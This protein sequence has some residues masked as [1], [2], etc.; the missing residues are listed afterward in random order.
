MSLLFKTLDNQRMKYIKYLSC[1]L[2][3]SFVVSVA[4]V[5]STRLTGDMG[6]AANDSDGDLLFHLFVFITIV[7]VIRA[8]ASAGSALILKRFSANAGYRFRDNFAKFFLQKP[9][10]SFEGSGSGEVLSVFTNDLPASVNLVSNGGVRMIADAITLAVA[11]VYMLVLNWWLTLIFFVS[12]PVLVSMQMF[13]AVPIQKKSE[14][15]LKAKANINEVLSDSFQNANMVV[16]YSIEDKMEARC[17]IAFS[18]WLKANKDMAQSYMFLVMVGMIASISPVLIIVALSAYQVI[19]GNF[20]IAEWIAYITLAGQTGNWLSMLSQRLN[21]VQSNA[22]GAKRVYEHMDTGVEDVDRGE[23]LRPKGDVAIS[24][25][26]VKFSYSQSDEQQ[27][28]LSD[29][30]QLDPSDE[31]QLAL[32]GVSFEIKKGSRTVFVGSSGSGKS[33]IMKLLLGLYTPQ[34]GSI[35]VMGS[36]SKEVSLSSLR[37]VFSYVPQ[38]NFLFPEP[39]FSNITGESTISDMAKLEKTCRDAGIHEFIQ[40]LPEGYNTVLSESAENI[41]GGQKQRIALARAFYRDA[42]IILFDEATSALDP[43]TEAAFL[44][45]FSN[46]LTGDKTVIMIAHRLKAINFCDT[47][48]LIDAGNIVAVGTHMELMETS[49]MYAELYK[50]GDEDEG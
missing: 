1:F 29:E 11:F 46:A 37:D 17:R 23:K 40:S 19:S 25:E 4:N 3:L 2:L 7:T 34:E 41:S 5:L 26:N 36:D 43:S 45:S 35:T 47:V 31:R 42:P 20:S 22:A 33:T 21:D 9:F 24:M 6:Q 15:K 13:L 32:N 48:I 30:Q 39:I 50:R 18:K 8:A 27:V 44:K 14:A 10:S 49:A 38:D 28:A 12:F 16:A